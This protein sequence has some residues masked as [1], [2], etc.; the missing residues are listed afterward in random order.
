MK[1]ALIVV[2]VGLAVAAAVTLVFARSP[3]LVPATAAAQSLTPDPLSARAQAIDGSSAEPTQ[4]AIVVFGPRYGSSPRIIH[5]PQGPEQDSRARADERDEVVA[6]IEDDDADMA[7]PPSRYRVIPLPRHSD[8]VAPKR[9]A[10]TP[11][12]QRR[13]DIAAVPH[14]GDAPIL[15]KLQIV[16]AA[17]RQSEPAEADARQSEDAAAPQVR[18]ETRPPATPAPSKDAAD[19]DDKLTPVYPTPRYD[20]KIEAND[21]RPSN[22]ASLTAD[23]PPP[24]VGYSPPSGLRDHPESKFGPSKK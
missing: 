2:F 10:H 3:S 18:G 12:P 8:A 24:P 7:P 22:G 5:V 21:S 19:S 1:K 9:Q 20:N 15:Q 17:P 6:P 23:I 11:A 14:H 13:S 4:V 16:P